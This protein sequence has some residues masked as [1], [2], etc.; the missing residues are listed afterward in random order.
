MPT[1]TIAHPVTV[2]LSQKLTSLEQANKVLANVLG[3]LGCPACLSGFDIRFT[4][5]N[6]LVIN[7]KSL[8]VSEF[9]G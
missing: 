3:R 1:A 8:N 2:R 9:G 7:P 4:H 6:D 5:I